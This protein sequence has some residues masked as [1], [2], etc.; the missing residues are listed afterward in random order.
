MTKRE[1]FIKLVEEVFAHIDIETFIEKCPEDKEALEFFEEFKN[2]PQKE[3]V[4][5]TEL[6]LKI[7]TFLNSH[8]EKSFTSKI[9]AEDL[10]TSSRTVSSGIRKLV[11]DGYCEKTKEDSPI[12]YHITAKGCQ[13]FI[14]K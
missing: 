6:G 2:A 5:M 7:L 14:D 1:R 9:I 4:E 8:P 13:Y 12:E 10:F 11:T 3:K